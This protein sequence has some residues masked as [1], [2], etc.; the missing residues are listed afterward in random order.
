MEKYYEYINKKYKV[1][2]T[3]NDKTTLKCSQCLNGI[4]AL[5]KKSL[6][7]D[8]TQESKYLHNDLY[9]ELNYIEY[10]YSCSFICNTCNGRTFSCGTGY[11]AEYS[12]H[13]ENVDF[14]VF[15]PKYFSPFI[16]LFNVHKSCPKSVVCN[17][18]DSFN[19]AWADISAS[20]NKLRIAIECLLVEVDP[21]LDKFRKLHKRIEYFAKKQPDIAKLLMAIKWLGNEASHEASLKE[22]DLAFAY[23][24]MELA[25]NKL[26][27]KSEEKLHELVEL[28][29]KNEG[30]PFS[31]W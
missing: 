5:D 31:E 21:E 17:L 11:H 20:A 14:P 9:W 30:K 10:I 27:D 25:L 16:P 15:I 3:E 4:L 28:V 1:T 2:F 7:Y 12:S 26:F 18:N 8:E 19:L 13:D 22:H 24:V 23:E 29:N 6:V